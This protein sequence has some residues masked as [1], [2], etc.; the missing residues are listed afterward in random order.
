MNNWVEIGRVSGVFG[1]KGWIK[2]H[3]YTR[4]R[5]GPLEYN[6]WQLKGGNSITAYNVEQ[7]RI[8][9]KGLIAKLREVDDRTMAESLIGYKIG[10]ST[11]EMKEIGLDEYYW[12]DLIG[13]SVITTEGIDL[14]KVAEM[15]ETGAND[16][17]IVNGDVRR[18]LPFVANTIISVDLHDEKI[19]V[20]W[21]PEF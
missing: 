15:M 13:L 8:Q 4:E 10:V 20:D 19:I 5:D 14:G 6:T 16:V 7:G 2:V 9:S 21:D 12:R 1:V 17:M 3:S 11:D 18:L